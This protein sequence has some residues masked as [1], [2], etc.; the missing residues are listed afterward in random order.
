MKSMAYGLREL[1]VKLKGEMAIL[2]PLKFIVLRA[3]KGILLFLL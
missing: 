3:Y 2:V 1:L